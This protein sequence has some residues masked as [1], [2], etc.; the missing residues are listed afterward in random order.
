[1]NRGYP[2]HSWML[3]IPGI[4]IVLGLISTFGTIVFNH[5][6]LS[7]GL[8]VVGSAAL[9]FLMMKK[10]RKNADSTQAPPDSENRS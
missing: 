8:I 5:P 4:L 1:M 9:V 2:N 6:I 3:V 10:K 7:M